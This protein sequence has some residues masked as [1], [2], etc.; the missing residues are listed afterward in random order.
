M[1]IVDLKK[2]KWSF[3]DNTNKT[4]LV[5]EKDVPF[6]TSYEVVSSKTGKSKVFNFSHSTGP[7]FDPST[8]W[9]YTTKGSNVLF[10][11]ANDTQI[12]KTRAN[13]YVQSKIK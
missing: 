8:Q 4:I 9:V 13:N 11:V 7:E 6:D 1:R 12:T 5:S 3:G 2:T 10:V